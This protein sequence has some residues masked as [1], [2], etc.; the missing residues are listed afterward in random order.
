MFSQENGT[1]AMGMMG[2]TAS[3]TFSVPIMGV[4]TQRLLTL[5]HVNEITWWT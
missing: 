5:L 4:W 3:F 2:T 1:T